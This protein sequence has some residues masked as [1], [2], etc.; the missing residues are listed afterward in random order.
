[1]LFR[2]RESHLTIFGLK[3][4]ETAKLRTAKGHGKSP[5]IGQPPLLAVSCI[6]VQKEVLDCISFYIRLNFKHQDFLYER[7]AETAYEKVY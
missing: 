5:N 7:E 1:M 6:V 3:H 2:A 4:W